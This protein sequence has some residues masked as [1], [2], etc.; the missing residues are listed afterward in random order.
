MNPGE[1]EYHGRYFIECVSLRR[2]DGEL[3]VTY[4][5]GEELSGRRHYSSE[6][7]GRSYAKALKWVEDQSKS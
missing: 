2:P 4:D 7:G 1:I 6:R 5:V 3:I